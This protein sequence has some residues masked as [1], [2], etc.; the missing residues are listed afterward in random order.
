MNPKRR[1]RTKWIRVQVRDLK[2]HPKLNRE[3]KPSTIRW[4]VRDMDLDLLGTFDVWRQGRDLFVINGQHRKLALEELGL[5]EWEV[6]CRVFEGMTLPEACEAALAANKSTPWSSW[7]K[8]EKGC[9][10]GRPECLGAR[11]VAESFGLRVT[12]TGGDG[13][14][15]CVD[16]LTKA[17]SL[18]IGG[19]L[20]EA[21]AFPLDAWGSTAAAVEGR[22]L[23]GFVTFT[24]YARKYEIDRA[25]FIK[26]LAKYEGGALAILAHARYESKHKGGTVA[27]RFAEALVDIYNKGRR[28]GQ[29]PP[30]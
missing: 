11:A 29:L 17:W 16:V 30:L 8:F 2:L 9:T 28:S 18:D 10:A 12:K 4:L 7:E 15:R 3:I 14:I 24:I 5:G 21:M 20:T 6:D 23:A 19:T 1:F 13:E 25:S 22:V 27:R 26:K